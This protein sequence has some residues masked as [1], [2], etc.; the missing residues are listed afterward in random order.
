[1]KS[2]KELKYDYSRFILSRMYAER[3][4]WEYAKGGI[5]ISKV[6]PYFKNKIYKYNRLKVYFFI[7]N[8]YKHI[9]MK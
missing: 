1:M 7:Y 4:N 9:A 2:Y 6:Q 5:G 3:T 8:Y